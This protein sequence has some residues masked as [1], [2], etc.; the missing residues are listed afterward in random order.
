MAASAK[1]LRLERIKSAAARK[2]LDAHHPLGAG[3]N[4]TVA[5]GVF[6]EGHL[7]G[8]LTLG[9][10]V[11]NLAGRAIGLRQ[12][13]FFELKKMHLSDACPRNSESRALAV[14][15]MLVRKHYPHI[16]AII[17]YC[18][19]DEKA[20]AYKASGWVALATHRYVR[21]IKANGRWWTIREANRRGIRSQ[22]TEKRFECRR[23][24]CLPL[25]EEMRRRT[26]LVA[27]S[28]ETDRR[29]ERSPVSKPDPAAQAHSTPNPH[30]QPTPRESS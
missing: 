13:Q 7:A 15:G 27:Q 17:T 8:V 18:D 5:L 16:E 24:W 1:S 25:T 28:L 19:N 30:P 29:A 11:S 12:H 9:G 14:V 21:D 20:A 26:S 6:W 4:F 23:K 2:Y 10:P 3:G 22:T